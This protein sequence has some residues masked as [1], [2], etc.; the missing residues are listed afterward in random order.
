MIWQDAM[1][2][3][4]MYPADDEFLNS[5]AEE[6]DQQVRRLRNHPSLVV[7]AGNNENEGCL[8]S[9]YFGTDSNFTLY[10]GDYIKLYVDVI[11]AIVGNNDPLRY[12]ETSCPSN[13]IRSVED[14]YVADN[15]SSAFYGDGK[16]I[17]NG[18]ENS[19]V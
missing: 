5:V 18:E 4:A 17:N 1:F 10:K 13:G 9:N 11:G 19:R 16:H 6:I 7:W 14:G 8:A 3:S 12:Y 2:A 15:P